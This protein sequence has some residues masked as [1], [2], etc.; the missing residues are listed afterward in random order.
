MKKLLILTSLL[1]SGSLW[2][3][4]KEIYCELNG[5]SKY[6]ERGS[7]VSTLP[8]KVTIEISLSKNSY[9]NEELDYVQFR[10]EGI[11]TPLYT[12]KSEFSSSIDYRKIYLK[13]FLDEKE[14]HP[15]RNL[16]TRVYEIEIEL[17]RLT[18]KAFLDGD[19]QGILID[20]NSKTTFLRDFLD[21]DGD[22]LIATEREF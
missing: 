20:S 10:Q 21:A 8:L 3:E 16:N 13:Y 17:N 5:F 1:I 7:V 2:A 9:G 15:I 18:G 14:R 6:L 19:I 11:Q 4:T 12:G 22:C